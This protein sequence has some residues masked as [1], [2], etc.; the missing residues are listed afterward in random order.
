[1]QQLIAG[2][3]SLVHL[4]I[5]HKDLCVESLE[6]RSK[7]RASLN[8]YWSTI[9]CFFFKTK[10]RCLYRAYTYPYK[11]MDT[12]STTKRIVTLNPIINLEKYEHIC[13]I[14]NLNSVDMFCHKKPTVHA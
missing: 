4:L 6:Y 13:Q 2:G 1:M 9:P 10:Y 12:A 14:K 11:C 7:K 3:S 8:V 5:A